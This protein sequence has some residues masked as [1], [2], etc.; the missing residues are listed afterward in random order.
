MKD[1]LLFGTIGL[2]VGVVVMQWTMPEGQANVTV[3]D[4]GIIAVQDRGDGPGSELL[5]LDQLGQVWISQGPARCWVREPLYDPPMPVNQ[6]KFWQY[7]M[8]ITLD[9]HTWLAMPSNGTYQWSD[10]GAWPG[11][12]VSS[13]QATFGSVKAQY[14]PKADKP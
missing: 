14:R 3:Q 4:A 7:S 13:N 6:I 1:R 12:P 5:A 11:A 10:C 9:N 8:I 2:L